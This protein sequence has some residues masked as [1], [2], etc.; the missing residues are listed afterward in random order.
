VNRTE[1]VERI[2]SDTSLTRTDVTA[3]LSA[4]EGLVGDT[5]KGGDKVQMAGFL[6]FE[7]GER[8][9]RTARNPRTGEALSIPAAL[10]PKVK[11]GKSF[12]D[13]LAG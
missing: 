1:L 4:F 12:K 2:A 3:V 5:V 10:V 6:T 7:R 11:I 13:A 8:A 9:A